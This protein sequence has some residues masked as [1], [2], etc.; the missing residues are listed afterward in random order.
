M[1]HGW[2][3]LGSLVGT[4]AILASVTGVAVWLSDKKITKLDRWKALGFA[5][6]AV[7]AYDWFIVTPMALGG[8]N[9]EDWMQLGVFSVTVV[10][11]VEL[12]TRWR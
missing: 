7:F 1:R 2:L 12:V 10:A 3:L 8:N 11:A 6:A 9:P 5:A 4:A